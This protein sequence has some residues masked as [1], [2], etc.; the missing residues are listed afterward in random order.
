ML[1]S[2]ERHIAGAV[3]LVHLSADS[4]KSPPIFFVS[5]IGTI[6]QYTAIHDGKAVPEIALDDPRSTLEQGYGESKWVTE[7]LLDAAGKKSGVS[8]AIWRVGQIAGPV[9][10]SKPGMWNKQE[11]MPSLIASVPVL[12]VVPRLPSGQ[13]DVAWIPVDILSRVMIELVE[14]DCKFEEQWTKYYHLVNPKTVK[15]DDFVPVIQ[16]HFSQAP[17]GERKGI[18]AVSTTEWLQLLEES[19]KGKYVDVARN[20]AV[21]LLDFYRALSRD[22]IVSLLDTEKAKK[23]SKTMWGLDPVKAE[24]MKLWLKQWNF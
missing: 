5:S 22:N 23:A 9:D 10:P 11:F 19:A 2:F 12:G 7:R 14:G 18:N 6:G 3:N 24:W 13:D 15:W 21:K 4:P 20:P 16:E 17:Q 8:A 1:K